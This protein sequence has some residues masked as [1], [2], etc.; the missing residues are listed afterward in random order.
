MNLRSA[1][2]ETT[3]SGGS[4]S[5]QQELFPQ[6]RLRRVR[7]TIQ[8]IFFGRCALSLS[9][10]VPN[11]SQQYS[12]DHVEC[13]RLEEELSDAQYSLGIEMGRKQSDI[14]QVSNGIYVHVYQNTLICSN[15]NLETARRFSHFTML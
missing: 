5:V 8:C 7:Q 4:G 9:V 12:F 10:S 6:I 1:N 15:V 3:V 14:V 2:S 13:E 11:K